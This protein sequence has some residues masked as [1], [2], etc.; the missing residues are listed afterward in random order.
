MYAGAVPASVH[1]AEH[2]SIAICRP[3]LVSVFS[4]E[5]VVAQSAHPSRSHQA[6]VYN[7][8][9]HLMRLLVD[10]QPLDRTQALAV[11]ANDG[12]ANAEDSHRPSSGPLASGRTS[13]RLRASSSRC[14]Q[15]FK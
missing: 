1:A 10:Y 4:S 9:G 2:L 13:M 8:V 3:L 12:F 15:I 14:S 6:P 5:L 11:L 7:D